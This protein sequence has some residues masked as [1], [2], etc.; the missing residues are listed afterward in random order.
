MGLIIFLA[1]ARIACTAK[2]APR[3]GRARVDALPTQLTTPSLTPPPPPPPSHRQYSTAVDEHGNPIENP[4][5]IMSGANLADPSMILSMERTLW[6]SLN[7]STQVTLAGTVLIA[8][9]GAATLLDV[10]CISQPTCTTLH[11]PCDVLYL[12]PMRHRVPICACDPML[13]PIDQLIN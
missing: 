3:R 11:A 6:G 4:Y 7:I 10:S 8:A 5:N 12:A 1:G 9:E 13:C 2:A